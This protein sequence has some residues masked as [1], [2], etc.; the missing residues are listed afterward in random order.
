[1]ASTTYLPRLFNV[2]CERPQTRPAMERSRVNDKESAGDQRINHV[3]NPDS[4]KGGHFFTLTFPCS[5]ILCI[6]EMKNESSILDR[7]KG[8]NH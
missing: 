4:E 5:L 3:P 1:M 8:K 2:V 6:V 7:R